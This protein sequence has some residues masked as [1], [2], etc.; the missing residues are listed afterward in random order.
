METYSGQVNFAQEL[1]LLTFRKFVKL[2]AFWKVQEDILELHVTVDNMK[3]LDVVQSLDKLSHNDA[4]FF[5]V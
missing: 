2:C 1:S 3:L 5:L 4:S